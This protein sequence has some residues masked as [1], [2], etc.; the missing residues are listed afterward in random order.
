[1]W[2]NKSSSEPILIFMAIRSIYPSFTNRRKNVRRYF[3]I[4][5]SARFIAREKEIYLFYGDLYIMKL[6]LDV[7]LTER[8][9]YVKKRCNDSNLSSG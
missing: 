4:M 2:Y 7:R 5:N 3:R 6:E 1:M 8:R 9:T